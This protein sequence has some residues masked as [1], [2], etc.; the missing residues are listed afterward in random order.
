MDKKFFQD[1]LHLFSSYYIKDDDLNFISISGIYNLN[2]EV[3][4]NLYRGQF[5]VII[6]ANKQNWDIPELY[7]PKVTIPHGFGHIYKDNKCCLGLNLEIENA[8]RPRTFISF[9]ENIVDPFLVNYL[10]FLKTKQYILGDRPHEKEGVLNYYSQF[11]NTSHYEEV[12]GILKYVYN[13]LKRKE[14]IKGHN[15]CPCGSN[16]KLQIGRAHV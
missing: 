2:V 8:W 5:T 9:L 1:G 7:L 16:K 6:Q 12:N 10:S 11:F 15:S 13:K 14:L 3:K 4:G